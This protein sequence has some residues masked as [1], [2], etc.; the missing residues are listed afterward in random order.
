MAK[1]IVVR[2]EGAE[3]RFDFA[4]L[5]RKKLYGSRR[6]MPLDAAGEPCKRAALTDDVSL[7]GTW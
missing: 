5:E 4:K 3:S 6:R 1:P 2:F 7:I